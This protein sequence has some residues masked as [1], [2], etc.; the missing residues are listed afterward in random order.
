MRTPHC[1]YSRHRRQVKGLTHSGY[2]DGVMAEPNK[3]RAKLF[4][5]DTTLHGVKYAAG[6]SESGD[7]KYRRYVHIGVLNN[8]T[9]F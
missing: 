6:V 5:S 9:V 3:D 7:G 4:A 8:K 1:I 2:L